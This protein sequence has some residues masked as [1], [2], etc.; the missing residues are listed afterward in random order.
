MPLPQDKIG[1]WSSTELIKVVKDI[2]DRQP[3]PHLPAVVIGDGTVTGALN[4]KGPL[5]VP[6]QT[7]IEFGKSGTPAYEHGWV[8]YGAPYFA[9]GYWKDP[10]GFI[11]LRGVIKSGTVGSSAFTLP[12]GAR[13]ISHPGPFI[14]LSNG[15]A[16]RVDIGTDGTITPIA[17]SSNVYVVLDGIYFRLT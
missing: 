11:H 17:P 1:D 8:D 9:P 12:P 7:F 13:P 10:L 6:N 2:I 14:V 3:P 15:A 4:L 16:G 5:V